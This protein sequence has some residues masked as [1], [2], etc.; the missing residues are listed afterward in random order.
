M[1]LPSASMRTKYKSIL[2][3]ASPEKVFAY[4][5]DIGN[6]GMHMQESSAIMMGS[7]F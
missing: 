1:P 3:Y 5:D 4:M 6:T 2:I 7:T